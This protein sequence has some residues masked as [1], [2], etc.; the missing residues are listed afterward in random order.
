MSVLQVSLSD[1]N[2]A[3]LLELSHETGKTPDQLANEAVEKFATAEEREEA[4]KLSRWRE[5]LTGVEGIWADRD[6]LPDFAELRRTWD[7]GDPS[8]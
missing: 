8:R 2:S 4:E 6:D 3:R 7:R 1:K 5:A